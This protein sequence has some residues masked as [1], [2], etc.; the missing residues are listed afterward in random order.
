MSTAP[1]PGPTEP[2]I[3]REAT[4]SVSGELLRR[5]EAIDS[6]PCRSFLKIVSYAACALP[7]RGEIAPSRHH[8]E[9]RARLIHDCGRLL[10]EAGNSED[11]LLAIG[12]QC[13]FD[14]NVS[15]CNGRNGHG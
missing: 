4:A 13:N 8:R 9:S 12:R 5:T 3:A 11:H 2:P 15:S 6:D 1:R 14:L 7:E 10:G